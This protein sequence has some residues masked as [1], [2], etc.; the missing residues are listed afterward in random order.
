MAKENP[1][2]LTVAKA[3]QAVDA[4]PNTIVAT[5]IALADVEARAEQAK[6]QELANMI[7]MVANPA[8]C[9][10]PITDVQARIRELTNLR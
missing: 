7:A 4:T 6:Q 5:L 8:A 2:Q 10:F 1:A 9:P 3:R